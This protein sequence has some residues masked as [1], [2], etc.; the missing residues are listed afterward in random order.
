MIDYISPWSCDVTTCS[1]N[2]DYQY[3]SSQEQMPFTIPFPKKSSLVTHSAGSR[4]SE[5][6]SFTYCRSWLSSN[7]EL[8][9]VLIDS[10]MC[11]TTRLN[12]NVSTHDVPFFKFTK[13]FSLNCT[14][15]VGEIMINTRKNIQKSKHHFKLFKRP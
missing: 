2:T 5:N 1:T 7:N 4:T 8:L 11:S 6:L 12:L 9:L 14:E 10:S 13:C 15:S 3:I